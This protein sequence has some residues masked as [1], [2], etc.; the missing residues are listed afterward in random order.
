[1][2]FWNFLMVIHI[3]NQ[4]CNAIAIFCF[5][6][7]LLYIFTWLRLT[8]YIT[9]AIARETKSFSFQ[10]IG[11]LAQRLPQLFRCFTYLLCFVQVSS[12]SLWWSDLKLFYIISETR[13]KWLF[14]FL[15]HW[16]WSPH[17]FVSL[18]RK[19]PVHL[20]LHTRYYDFTHYPRASLNFLPLS[21]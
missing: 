19:L 21:Q 5:F 16:K 6:E 20:L 4:V 11:L 17:I 9:D 2:G 18:S 3:Q 1:M 10:A 14:A 13:L 8:E 7:I 15:M 12:T